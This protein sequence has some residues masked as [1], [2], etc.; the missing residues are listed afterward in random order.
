MSL[1]IFNKTTVKSSI[2]LFPQRWPEAEFYTVPD[3]GHG[4]REKGITGRLVAA[5]DK[6]RKI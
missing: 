2:S 5:T 1:Y 4:A 6:F 3:S